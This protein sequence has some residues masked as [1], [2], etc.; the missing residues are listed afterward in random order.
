MSQEDDPPG[1]ARGQASPAGWPVERIAAQY[2]HEI[3]QKFEARN[4]AH[5]TEEAADV[6][7]MRREDPRAWQAWQHIVARDPG[8]GIRDDPDW[9][10]YCACQINIQGNAVRIILP[11]DGWAIGPDLIQ[12]LADASVVWAGPAVRAEVV[13]G[14]PRVVV[15]LTLVDYWDDERAS[16][17]TATAT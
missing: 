13:E 7:R 4:L 12:A 11:G 8:A 1:D 5:R 16:A 6:E 14:A 17:A 15:E 10:I 9:E 2:Q 3:R